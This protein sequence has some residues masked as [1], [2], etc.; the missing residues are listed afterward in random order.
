M[1]NFAKSAKASSETQKQPQDNVKSTN[2][3]YMSD[4]D[5]NNKRQRDQV[6]DIKHQTSEDS[7]TTNNNNINDKN[8][9][10][11][12]KNE[13][14]DSNNPNNQTD[15][16]VPKL[17][18]PTV[19]IPQKKKPPVMHSPPQ[20]GRSD[21]VYTDAVCISPKFGTLFTTPVVIYRECSCDPDDLTSENNPGVSSEAAKI[22]KTYKPENVKYW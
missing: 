14:N 10:K 9:K 4:Q 1:M 2:D 12:K 6:N 3:G 15:V 18:C 20:I 5:G 11:K 13:V 19:H 22:F 8:R 21:Q 17:P 7:E 16:I